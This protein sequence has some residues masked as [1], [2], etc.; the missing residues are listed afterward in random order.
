MAEV[1]FEW[2]PKKDGENRSKHGVSFAEAQVA[3]L[4][5][6]RVIAKDLAHGST[7]KRYYCFG[8]VGEGIMTVRF[9]Y[10]G[11]TVRIIGA[12]YWRKGK[13]IYERENQIR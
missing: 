8:V 13:Q 12:G 10:R 2:D 3:F 6:Q 9:T 5:P 7:E 11:N 4:D 1:S